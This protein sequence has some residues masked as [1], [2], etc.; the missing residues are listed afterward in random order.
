VAL[1]VGDLLMAGLS[2][3]PA[4]AYPSGGALAPVLTLDIPIAGLGGVPSDAVGVALNVT[5]T[6]PA[7][8]GFLVVYACGEHR[9]SLTDHYRASRATRRPHEQLAHFVRKITRTECRRTEPLKLVAVTG[10]SPLLD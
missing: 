5:V 4:H 1:L 6:N 10:A 3:I 2:P 7:S 9:S 8:A